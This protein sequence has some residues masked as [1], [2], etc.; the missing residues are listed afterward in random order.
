MEY[1]LTVPTLLGLEKPIADELKSLGAENVTSEN[2][3]VFF[4]GDER[5]IART[6]ICSRFS[7][8][9]QILVGSFTAKSFEE[10]FEGTKA[11]EW[12]NFIGKTDAFPVKG[13]SVSSTL[14]SVRDCQSIIKKAVVERLKSKYNIEWFEETGSIYQIQFS[15]M[16]DRVLL[17][18]DTSGTALHKRGY[19][20]SAN[21]APIKETLA[22]SLCYF[23][24]LRPYHKLY[25]PMCG[26]GTI[27]IEG[28]LMAHNI[29]PGLNRNFSAERFSFIERNIWDEERERARDKI[30]HCEDFHAYGSDI[31]KNALSFARE[32]AKR[33]GV[34]KYIDFSLKN[35]SEFSPSTER[36]TV[37]TN[38]PYGERLMENGE[39]D[40]L[41]RIL[42]KAFV[43]KHGFSYSVIT[44]H[45]NFEQL[46]GREADKRR[47]LYNGMIKC[48][49]YMY[50]K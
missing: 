48:Q 8:R 38:P 31:D 14:F 7:E 28:A 35:V 24:R 37:I 30:K 27:L 16:K 3:R 40:E 26:S 36:G 13:Y 32:N 33:A 25:D 49:L 34:E 46:F 42:G 43:Q 47:K 21:E 44:P 10:L 17:L 11:L 23:S 39:V 1:N 29:A 19:R 41:Y 9:V 4:T 12:E 6:N 5:M 22:A 45:E 18:I 20:L 15:V 50:F 2:G